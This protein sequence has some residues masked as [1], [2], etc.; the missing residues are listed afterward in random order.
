ME[1]KLMSHQSDPQ[2]KLASID[3]DQWRQEIDA[4]TAATMSALDAIVNEL[5]NACSGDGVPERLPAR[6]NTTIAQHPSVAKQSHND[7]AVKRTNAAGSSAKKS[8]SP[9]DERSRL[10]SIKEKLA[11]R[12]NKG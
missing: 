2:T 8:N 3:L 12:I 7:S 11:S 9:S 6:R 1:G 5:S 4:F 10:A